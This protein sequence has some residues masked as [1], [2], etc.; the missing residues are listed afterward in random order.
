VPTW[1]MTIDVSGPVNDDTLS[2]EEKRDRIVQILRD[3]GWQI[4]SSTAAHG[5]VGWMIRKLAEA[6]TEG[7]FRS[8]WM[9]IRRLADEDRVWL[10]TLPGE[11]V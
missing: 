8:A 4:V 5:G 7:E 11:R 1:F 6:G 9:W 10:A 2:F 3:S